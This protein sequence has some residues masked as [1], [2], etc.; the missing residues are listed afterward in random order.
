MS[1]WCARWFHGWMLGLG[2][3]ALAVH[4]EY[5]CTLAVHCEHIY[6]G[7]MCIV[8]WLGAHVDHLCSVQQVLRQMVGMGT[9]GTL[10]T[11]L[12]MEQVFLSLAI[13]QIQDDI[14]SYKTST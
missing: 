11:T 13:K 10:R 5:V 8:H 7:H 3:C 4:C 9:L 2:A 1:R 6:T 12:S 14:I